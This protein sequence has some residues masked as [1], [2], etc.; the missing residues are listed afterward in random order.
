MF[1]VSFVVDN[2]EMTLLSIGTALS[3]VLT[4][5]DDSSLCNDA[6]VGTAPTEIVVI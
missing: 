2:G 5:E 4:T 3:I 6:N 1:F